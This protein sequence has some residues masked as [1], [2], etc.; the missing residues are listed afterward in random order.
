MPILADIFLAW[1]LPVPVV[2]AIALDHRPGTTLLRSFSPL[3]ALHV[4]NALVSAQYPS[5]VGAPANKP[6]LNYLATLNLK[7]NVAI[8]DCFLQ[9]K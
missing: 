1:G 5:A 9:E 8:W 6:D 2:E 4:D 3:R 7:G